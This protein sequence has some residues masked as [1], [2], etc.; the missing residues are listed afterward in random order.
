MIAQLPAC[1]SLRDGF[2]SRPVFAYVRII[3][4]ATRRWRYKMDMETLL[5]IVPDPCLFERPMIQGAARSLI[6]VLCLIRRLQQLGSL[7]SRRPSLDGG[8]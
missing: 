1:H 8:P 7:A 5:D 2:V 6:D 4:S 3:L